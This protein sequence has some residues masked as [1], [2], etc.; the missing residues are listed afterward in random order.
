MQTN[1]EAQ[2][3]LLINPT[4]ITGPLYSAPVEEVVVE[5]EEVVT[6]EEED[7]TD[8]SDTVA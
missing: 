5:E 4:T 7:I 2:I 8:T 3:A 1:L 6:E